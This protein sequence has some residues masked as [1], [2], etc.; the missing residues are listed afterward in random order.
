[1]KRL[2]TCPVCKGKL[3]VKEFYCTDCGTTIKGEFTLGDILNLPKDKLEFLMDYLKLRGNLR[4]LGNQM[5]VSYPTIRA[6]FDE[7]L[8]ALGIESAAAKKQQDEEKKAQISEILKQI[9]S[10]DIS[11]KEGLK[12]I[13]EL[14]GR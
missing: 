14:K 1:M 9:D 12:K 13:K 7:L 10:G 4:E 6:R 2:N 3:I 11:S 5:G 8:E